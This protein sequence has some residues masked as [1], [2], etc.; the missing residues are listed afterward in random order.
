[1]TTERVGPEEHV[2]A[3][4]PGWVDPEL[5]Q[6]VEW[7]DGDIVVSVPGKSGTTW[8]MN[9]VHQLRSG[10]DPDFDDIYIEVPWLEFVRGP[11]DSRERRLE[12][13]RSMTTSRRRAFKTHA[14]PPGLPYIEPGP[15]AP[16]VKYVVVLRNP[17]EAIVSLRP[18]FEGHS[19]AFFDHWNSPKS[20]ITRPTF[21]EFYREVLSGMPVSDMFFGFLAS[22]W[23]L[24]DKPNVKIVHFSQLKNAPNQVIPE[25]AQFLGFSPTPEQWPRILEY[26]SFSWMKKHQEKFEIRHAADV[27]VLDSGAMVRKGVVGAAR[28]DGMTEEIS[29]EIR[30]MGEKVITNPKLLQWFYEGGPLPES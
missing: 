17:E 30:A 11:T 5:Q 3:G 19:Q 18:F 20:H 14:A 4:L 28:D 26:C 7:R 29:R 27:P 2:P 22:W 8:M 9:I 13:F 6:Q 23:S 12:R 15:N 24:R 10:G 25:L 21:V 1:M 16:D